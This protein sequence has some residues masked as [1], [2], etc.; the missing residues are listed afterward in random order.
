[1]KHHFSFK[2]SSNFLLRRFEFDSSGL[3]YNLTSKNMLLVLAWTGCYT[4]IH[5]SRW[6]G[7]SIMQ[8]NYATEVYSSCGSC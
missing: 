3:N 1:M 7:L 2:K 8:L 4:E 5:I 6:A